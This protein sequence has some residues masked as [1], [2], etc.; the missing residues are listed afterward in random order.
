MYS[1]QPVGLSWKRLNTI[2]PQ[3]NV[4]DAWNHT[5]I[6]NNDSNSNN[7]ENHNHL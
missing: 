7:F 2:A 5:H 3:P 1:S 4:V 6:N